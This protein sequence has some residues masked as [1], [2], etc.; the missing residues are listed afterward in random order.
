MA[1]VQ[2][3]PYAV[4][5]GATPNSRGGSTGCLIATTSTGLIAQLLGGEAF[6]WVIFVVAY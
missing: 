1:Q 3:G 5:G 6:Y 4:V 2:A